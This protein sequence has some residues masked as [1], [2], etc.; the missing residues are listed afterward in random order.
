MRSVSRGE[1]LSFEGYAQLPTLSKG[2]ILSGRSG[3]VHALRGEREHQVRGV[4]CAGGLLTNV[5]AGAK[6]TVWCRRLRRLP[7]GQVLS[8]VWRDR[9]S[10][11]R[12]QSD[13]ERERRCR[14]LSHMWA[15]GDWRKGGR[16]GVHPVRGRTGEILHTFAML[17]L[18][19]WCILIFAT[20]V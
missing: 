2:D 13:H 8:G 14:L 18:L 3:A 20:S 9:V 17:L 1:F 5:P 11:V 7:E 15:G 4:G 19:G 16:A 10:R 12:G 6:R